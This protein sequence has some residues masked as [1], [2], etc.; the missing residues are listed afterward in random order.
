MS[1]A[2]HANLAYNLAALSMMG[3]HDPRG[4]TL[5]SLA[6]RFAEADHAEGLDRS[7]HLCYV[8]AGPFGPVP[9]QNGD[10]GPVV[11]MPVRI[12]SR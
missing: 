10:E 4:E 2:V 5:E 11:E 6:R 1:A 12:T 7:D 8:A 9:R 3:A